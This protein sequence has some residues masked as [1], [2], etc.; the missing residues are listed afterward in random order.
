MPRL[1]DARALS[2]RAE[3]MSPIVAPP[4]RDQEVTAQHPAA[5]FYPRPIRR[6]FA[7][8]CLNRCGT[9]RRENMSTAYFAA[10]DEA[11]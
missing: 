2:Q 1:T 5:R 9:M 4:L 11:A 3:I 7:R 8:E 6:C 10:I